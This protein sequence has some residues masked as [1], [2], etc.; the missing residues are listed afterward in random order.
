MILIYLG[1]TEMDTKKILKKRDKKD[2]KKKH[3]KKE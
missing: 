2:K 1:K 3:E